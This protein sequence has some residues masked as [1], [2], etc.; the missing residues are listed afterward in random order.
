[1]PRVRRATAVPTPQV[2]SGRGVTYFDGQH[3]LPFRGPG[4]AGR[5]A[6]NR[7]ALDDGES[8]V[9]IDRAR[10]RITVRNTHRYPVQADHRRSDLPRHRQVD[11]GARVPA[12][13]PPEAGEEEG[14][15]ISKS[16]CTRTGP[17]ATS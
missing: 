5:A 13:R 17:R 1:M 2:I 12:W 8:R 6:S 4:H 16:T 11:G 15:Q 14:D 9:T 10:R 3:P 7:L